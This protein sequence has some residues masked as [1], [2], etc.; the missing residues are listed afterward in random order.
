MVFISKCLHTKSLSLKRERLLTCRVDYYYD[1]GENPN[2]QILYPYKNVTQ[3]WF[4]VHAKVLIMLFSSI[5]L[6]ITYNRII[7]FGFY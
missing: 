3:A 5:A 6:M 7:Q 1:F 4:F 2:S